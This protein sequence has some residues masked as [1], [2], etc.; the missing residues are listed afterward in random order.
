MAL[1]DGGGGSI[2]VSP[3]ALHAA[4]GRLRTA[5]GNARE[6][7]ASSNRTCIDTGS[8]ELN[9]ALS[10]FDG[11]WTTEVTRLT[12]AADQLGSAVTAAGSAYLSLDTCIVPSTAGPR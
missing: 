6:A 11:R 4:G 10:Q 8:P 3:D 12:D 1:A 5:A 2:R 7:I 9:A